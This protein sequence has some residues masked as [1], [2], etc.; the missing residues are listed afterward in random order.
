VGLADALAQAA[1]PVREPRPVDVPKGW[2]PG[3]RWSAAKGEGMIV[4]DARADQPD[5][6][7]WAEI[8]ADWGLDPN[9]LEIVDGSIEL[10]GWDSPIGM[11]GGAVV[12]LKR[13]KA[14]LRWRTE[15]ADHAD[16]EALCRQA[17]KRKPRKAPVIDVADRALVVAFSDWQLGKALADDTPVLTPDGWVAHGDIKPGDRVYGPEGKPV[18]V[19]AV[20]G[21]DTH[22]AYLMTWDDGSTTVASADHVWEGWRRYN[23]G[24]QYTRRRVTTTT[25]D[26]AS[27]RSF[28]N[29][30]RESIA[31]PFHVDLCQ[32]IELPESVQPIDPYQFGAWLGD[33]NRS[34]GYITSSHDDVPHWRE[35]WPTLHL[36]DPNHHAAVIAVDGLAVALRR[37]G[38][39]GNKHIPDVYLNASTE[40]RLAIVQGLMDTDGSCTPSGTCEFTQV[41][42]AV[43][44]GTVHLLRSLG[45]KVKRSIKKTT[46]QDAHR[47][48]FTPNADLWYQCVFRM[49]RKADRLRRGV[50]QW[51]FSYLRD[52]TPIGKVFAQ[53]ITVDGSLYLAGDSLK[54]THNCEERVNGQP[55]NGTAGTVDRI[56]ASID[57]TIVRINELKYMKR[58]VGAVYLVGMGDLVEQCG[59]YY[60]SQ[61]ATVDLNRREQMRVARRLI[62][63]AVDLLVDRTD[64][65]I[66]LTGV[67]GNHGENRENGKA[68]TDP[69]DNDDLAVIE[70]VAEV[71][72]SNPDR[73]GERV[74][75]FL[76][77]MLSMCLDIAGVP[78]GFSH[79]HKAGSGATPEAKLAKWW[80]GQVMGYQPVADARILVTGH[81]HH[82]ALSESTGRTWMQCPAM[83]PG[84]GWW[85]ESTGQSSP[86]GMLTFVA[87]ATT[88]RG[89]TDLAVL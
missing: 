14:R 51:S 75:S 6:A 43:A 63:H 77:S 13:Y 61:T 32:P 71:M 89:W 23:A 31:R 85:T 72:A 4:T 48:Q 62:L 19:T 52:V 28:G 7:I 1:P 83:D 45:I 65:R 86:T 46:H 66:V 35:Q 87:D 30:G 27:W 5:A 79:G 58:P 49:Q 9:A 16:I 88:A 11:G 80:T 64:C 74:S 39:K 54:V 22:D 24:G 47:I 53:C 34:N 56:I 78:V 76:P 12:R 8:I 68:I 55:T 67:A 50:G 2:E 21:S 33:G 25:Q 59:G 15:G 84:S 18:D 3:V 29:R 10:I 73:Y 17:S 42:T 37:L 40:Q 57:A 81:Y 69:T 38:V 20:T 26:L 44:D 70:Q 36:V 82:L 60:P 41:N